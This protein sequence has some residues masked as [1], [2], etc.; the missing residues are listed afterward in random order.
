MLAISLGGIML[1]QN[2][3]NGIAGGLASLSR[4]GFAWKRVAEIFRA[5]ARNSEQD[6]PAP[7]SRS[8]ALGEAVLEARNLRYDYGNAARPV[9]DG[10]NIAIA[11]G[12]RIGRGHQ[13]EASRHLQAFSPGSGHPQA[14]FSCSMD[15]IGPRS[16][17]TG[18]VASRQH[19]NSMKTISCP[20]HLHSIY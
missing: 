14:D 15:W 9:I 19:H 3:L 10:A 16:V 4:A 17:M 5:G 11:R 8:A 2:A 1:G 20:E 18:T 7:M 6:V 12:D 13:A